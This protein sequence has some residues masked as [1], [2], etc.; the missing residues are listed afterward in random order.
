[1]EGLRGYLSTIMKDGQ[2]AIEGVNGMEGLRGYLSASK[3]VQKN[4]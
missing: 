3:W 2:L 4:K 1:M